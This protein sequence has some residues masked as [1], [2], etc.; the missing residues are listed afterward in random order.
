MDGDVLERITALLS[1]KGIDHQEIIAYLNLPKGTFSNWM[2]KKSHS[3]YEHI[4]EIADFLGVSKQ[5]LITGE[6]DNYI[7]E[8]RTCLTKDDLEMVRLFNELDPAARKTFKDML[9]LVHG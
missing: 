8:L 2:R 3:Y 9:V 7:A 1:E 6:D 4:T 5:Y